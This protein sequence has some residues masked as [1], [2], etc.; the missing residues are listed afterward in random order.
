MTSIA[1]TGSY[2][3]EP[4]DHSDSKA[5]FVYRDYNPIALGV[6]AITAVAAIVFLVVAIV[7][8]RLDSGNPTPIVLAL[9]LP[10]ILLAFTRWF[11]LLGY[12]E[13]VI[14]ERGFTTRGPFRS[15][16][17]EVAAETIR[18]VGVSSTGPAL[19]AATATLEPL[20]AAKREQV[21]A[22]VTKSYR[23]PLDAPES[24]YL[25]VVETYASEVTG[26]L[27]KRADAPALLSA[28]AT[29]ERLDE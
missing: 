19:I 25:V 18:R 22:A 15:R 2:F 27:I 8:T 20:E 6:A 23:K 7:G 9:V 17:R 10:F 4:L 3:A 13:Y 11:L 1:P 5:S 26:V 29:L 12:N 14:D 28:L 21:L 16:Q 24:G